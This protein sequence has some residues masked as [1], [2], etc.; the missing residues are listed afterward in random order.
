MPANLLAGEDAATHD[1]SSVYINIILLYKY[2]IVSLLLHFL[3]SAFLYEDKYHLF[4]I[5]REVES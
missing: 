1:I 3:F 4:K 5:N 2:S